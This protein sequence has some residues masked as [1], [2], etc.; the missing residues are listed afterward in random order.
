[1]THE[2]SVESGNATISTNSSNTSNKKAPR[3]NNDKMHLVYRRPV[4]TNEM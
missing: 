4:C 1:M 3:T 2:T